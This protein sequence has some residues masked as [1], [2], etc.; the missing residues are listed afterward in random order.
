MSDEKLEVYEKAER[1]DDR[2]YLREY[3]QYIPSAEYLAKVVSSRMQDAPKKPKNMNVLF[4]DEYIAKHAK[5]DEDKEA[6]KSLR[7]TAKSLYSKLSKEEK[8]VLGARRE[9]E[10][11]KWKLA[12]EAYASTHPAWVSPVSPKRKAVKAVEPAKVVNPEDSDSDEDV[13]VV[14]DEVASESESD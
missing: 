14:E 8:T 10:M 11:G 6:L 13:E 3:A 4:V 5:G 12:C 9:T 2:R 7:E 1:A